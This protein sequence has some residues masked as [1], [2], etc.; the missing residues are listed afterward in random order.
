VAPQLSFVWHLAWAPAF[1]H[2][3]SCPLLIL[4]H[5]ASQD[6]GE[7][8]FLADLIHL[9]EGQVVKVTCQPWGDGISAS[10]RGSHG[11]DKVDVHQVLEGS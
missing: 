8:A 7:D 1:A 3:L 2:G 11:T 5:P 6:G 4:T 10:P 9:G